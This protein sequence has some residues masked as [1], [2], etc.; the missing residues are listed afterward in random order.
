[1]TIL[2]PHG[3]LESP[4]GYIYRLPERIRPE[5]LLDNQKLLEKVLPGIV[6]MMKLIQNAGS[7]RVINA[8]ILLGMNDTIAGVVFGV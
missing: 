7:A 1:M 8:S 2:K 6:Q 4:G 5:V 3:L